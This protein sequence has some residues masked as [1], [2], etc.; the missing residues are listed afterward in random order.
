MIVKYRGSH[1]FPGTEFEGEEEF[2]DDTDYDIIEDVIRELVM[3]KVD[4]SWWEV[5]GN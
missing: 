4:W 3:R 2:D 5:E 1:G